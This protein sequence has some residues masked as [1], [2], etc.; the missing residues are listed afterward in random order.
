[1]TAFERRTGG[2]RRRLS[3]A[4]RAAALLIVLGKD[5]APKL[6]QYLDK[7]EVR[8]IARAASTLGIV[9]RT[10]LETMI[11][12]FSDAFAHGPDVV[13][14]L[15]E[16]QKLVAGTLQPQELEE[17]VDDLAKVEV[18]DVWGE[19][20][21]LEGAQL[22]GALSEEAPW[23][24]G[25]I[26][27][28]IDAE[29]AAR[30]LEHFDDLRRPKCLAA[31]LATTSPAPIAVR[32]LQDG[33]AAHAIG[34]SVAKP[35]TDNPK[36]VAE[37]VNRFDARASD[38]TLAYLSSVAPEEARAVRALVFKFE[39]VVQL[40]QKDRVAVFDGLPTERVVLALKAASPELIEATLSSLGARARRMVESELS[41]SSTAPQREVLAA[42]R[43]I[44]EAALRLSQA[45]LIS[46]R[47]EASD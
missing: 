41:G 45:G 33:L 8:E 37:I 32:W 12:E 24:C 38:E 19:V 20:G 30:V 21:R 17:A 31:M 36:R 22:A 3:G 34:R 18:V 43:M 7:D 35:G 29:Q 16:A 6:L 46:L 13:G 47:P 42:Q 14:T 4:Q 40:S 11:D 1:M 25:V 2:D 27:N 15:A 9:N 5:A 28:M 10:A 26:L 23:L 44:V 39:E